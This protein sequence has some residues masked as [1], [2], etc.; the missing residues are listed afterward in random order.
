MIYITGDTHGNFVRFSNQRMKQQ[1]LSLSEDDYIIVCGD[2]GM[3]WAKDKTFDYDCENFARKKY[4]VLWIQGNHENYDMISEYP[5]EEWHGGKVR[6]IV[7]DKVILL[8]RGQVFDIEG[9]KFFTFGGASSHDIQGGIL[10]RKD[11]DFDEKQKNAHKSNLPYR[12]VHESWWAEE[13]PNEEEMNEGRVN[14]EKNGYKVDYVLTHCCSTP[15]QERLDRPPCR[16]FKPDIL[17]NY[18]EEIENKLS[19]RHWFFGHYHMDKNIDE[20]HSVLYHTIVSLE[21]YE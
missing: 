8:E 16:L 4:T 21:E 7:K 13:L 11:I 2:F 18:L 9:K 14:L 10:D 17:T 12:I 19:Y 6:H 15:L 1:G 3:C 5:V 20:K